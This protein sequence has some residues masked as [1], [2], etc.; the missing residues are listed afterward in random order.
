MLKCS[1]EKNQYGTEQAEILI[2]QDSVKVIFLL[3]SNSNLFYILQGGKKSLN[4][5]A[6]D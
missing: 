3:I 2:S 6:H 5:E 1:L 4:L